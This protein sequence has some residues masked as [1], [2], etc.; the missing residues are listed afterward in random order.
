MQRSQFSAASTITLQNIAFHKDAF[1][2]SSADLLLPVALTYFAQRAKKLDCQFVWFANTRSVQTLSMSF[3]CSL[4]L[5]ST[6]SRISLPSLRLII[7]GS[8]TAPFFKAKTYVRNFIRTKVP[9][10]FM[11][12]KD[13]GAVLFESQ[14]EVD[15]LDKKS[16]KTNRLRRRKSSKEIWTG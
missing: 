2:L 9:W 16:S 12:H 6:L 14:Q 11:Y 10:I 5:Q 3:R 1:V 13:L 15:A 4:R 7:Q 8:I